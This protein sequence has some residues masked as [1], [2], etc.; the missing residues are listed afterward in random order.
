M[1]SLAAGDLLA[2]S[3]NAEAWKS[4]SGPAQGGVG[5]AEAH[6]HATSF[7]RAL[8]PLTREAVNVRVVHRKGAFRVL[9]DMPV[10]LLPSLSVKRKK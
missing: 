2:S 8:E 7:E 6:A 1:G 3:V 10:A 5:E 9:V 4:G